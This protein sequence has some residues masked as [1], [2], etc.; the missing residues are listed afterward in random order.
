MDKIKILVT[1]AGGPAAL[2]FCRSLRDAE[3]EYEIIGVDCNKYYLNLMDVDHKYLIPRADDLD[4]INVLNHLAAKH[5]VDFLHSQPDFELEILSECREELDVKTNFPRKEVVRLCLDKWESYKKWKAVGIKVPETMLLCSKNDLLTAFREL[6]DTIWI[7]NTKGAGGRGSL[8]TSDIEMATMWINYCEG[9]GKFSAAELLSSRTITWQ[10]IWDNGELI[11]AQ[12]RERAYWE[13]GVKTFSGVTGL[14][15][16]GLTVDDSKVN[17][18]ALATVLATDPIPH[19][20]F[21]VDM[22]YDFD[23]IPNPTEINIARFFTT[24][25]FFTCAGINFP[26]I[27]VRVSLG[28]EIEKLEKKVNPLP[29]G[30]AWVRGMDS[31]PVL[32]TSSHFIQAEE[33]LQR[34]RQ[35]IKKTKEV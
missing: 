3:T 5:Q 8:P 26:D 2:G 15:G 20:I 14:T 6:G 27:F 30:Y 7:R 29:V 1:G 34:L 16:T 13:Y 9:W 19:G 10:S 33:D 25:Y 4:Y 12:S 11:V 32:T 24:H 31:E 28:L 18:V 22:T 23:S 17:E 35:Q 21:S